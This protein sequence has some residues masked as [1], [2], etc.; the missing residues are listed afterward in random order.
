MMK[1]AFSANRFSGYMY[2][3]RCQQW[4]PCDIISNKMKSAVR[5]F[6]LSEVII[7]QGVKARGFQ[8]FLQ[9]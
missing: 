3:K 7:D 5:C 6:F 9:K 4:G 2:S 8:L 1:M